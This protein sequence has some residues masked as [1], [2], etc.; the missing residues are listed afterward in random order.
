MTWILQHLETRHIPQNTDLSA[1]QIR[2]TLTNELEDL[3][4][5]AGGMFR[6]N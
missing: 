3:L 2:Q 5:K 1:S 4:K 6:K